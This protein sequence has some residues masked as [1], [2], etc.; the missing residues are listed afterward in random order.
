MKDFEVRKYI[1]RLKKMGLKSPSDERS[2]RAIVTIKQF[3]EKNTRAKKGDVLIGEEL[4]NAIWSKGIKNPP[5]K[6][7]IFVQKLK[8]DKVFVNL[9]GKPLR[10]EKEKK[11]EKKDKKN[12]KSLE[13]LTAEPKT[14]EKIAVEKDEEINS[15]KKV[16]DEA[17]KKPVAKFDKNLNKL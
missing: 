9:E 6:V 8:N 10:I 4:N 5:T 2:K 11:D 7:S 13:D 1:I 17:S 12:E 16:K 3:I 14:S 15:I